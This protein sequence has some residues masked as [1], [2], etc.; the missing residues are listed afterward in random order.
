M[1]GATDPEELSLAERVR[2]GDADAEEELVERYHRPVYAIAA[3]RL[4]DHEAAR[5]LAQEILLMVLEALRAGKLREVDRLSAFVHITTRNRINTH[6][7]GLLRERNRPPV[8]EASPVVTPEE[9]YEQ[10]QRQAVVRQ[11]LVRLD[12]HD[13]K[14]LLLTLVDGLKP[15]EIAA[16]LGIPPERL[17][18]RKSRALEKMRQEVLEM[19]RNPGG[20]Y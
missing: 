5:D 2:G 17:R 15:R 19:S 7:T 10:A 6:L 13:R 16:R 1:K 11:A 3:A 8:P 20:E 18:K 4:R 12:P 9:R 14:I